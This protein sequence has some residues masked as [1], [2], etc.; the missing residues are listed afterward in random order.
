ME[1]L[2]NW[3]LWNQWYLAELGILKPEFETGEGLN[4]RGWLLREGGDNLL[5][6]CRRN[7]A[8]DEAFLPTGGPRHRPVPVRAC[9]GRFARTCAATG[10]GRFHLRAAWDGRTG[11]HCA[12]PGHGAPERPSIRQCWG[13]TKAIGYRQ[14][15]RAKRA[16]QLARSRCYPYRRTRPRSVHRGGARG[17]WKRR[18]RRRS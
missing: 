13:N 5:S 11:W 14:R 4:W 10:P 1:P 18:L 8:L 15:G 17:R 9:P 3:S 6:K 12:L 2:A 7:T 16:G